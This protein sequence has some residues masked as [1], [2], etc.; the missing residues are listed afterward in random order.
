MA[1]VG[2]GGYFIADPNPNPIDLPPGGM[3]MDEV[4]TDP[5]GLPDPDP[6]YDPPG[7]NGLLHPSQGE[8]YFNRNI[9]A[10]DQYRNQGGRVVYTSKLDELRDIEESIRD[11]LMRRKDLLNELKKERDEIE[12]RLNTS[13][14]VT[15]I[16]D[17]MFPE[18]SDVSEDG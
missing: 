9:P 13:G 12:K 5:P 7:G 4:K 14:K 17:T 11:L 15:E 2:L 6:D 10:P 16:L 1:G 18:E 3:M 8:D